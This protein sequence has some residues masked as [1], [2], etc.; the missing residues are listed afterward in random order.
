[1]ILKTLAASAYARITFYKN[2]M[3]SLSGK[4][5]QKP[6]DKVHYLDQQSTCDIANLY[7]YFGYELVSLKTVP[8]TENGDLW[9]SKFSNGH[10]MKTNSGVCV[11]LISYVTSLARLNLHTIAHTV[12]TAQPTMQPVYCDTDSY[13]FELPD[14]MFSTSHMVDVERLRMRIKDGDGDDE[15]AARLVNSFK[16]CPGVRALEE[17][18]IP[19]PQR[20]G[21]NETWSA[22]GDTPLIDAERLGSCK[23]EHFVME[24]IFMGKK[25]YGLFAL[26]VARSGSQ[27]KKLGKMKGVHRDKVRYEDLE[28]MRDAFLAQHKTWDDEAQVARAG[29]VR[30]KQTIF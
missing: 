14:T 7:K 4:F 13:L 29:V 26:D 18:Q 22:E 23:I 20:L 15:C 28:M 8:S 17:M 24:G 25:M 12:V 16:E 2:L 19:C 3:N 6:Y 5:G 21:N 30:V 27:W 1:M 9:E 10:E 11:R